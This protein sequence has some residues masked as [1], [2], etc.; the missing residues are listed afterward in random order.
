MELFTGG[1]SEQLFHHCYFAP[2]GGGEAV[3]VLPASEGRQAFHCTQCGT[4]VV[5]GKKG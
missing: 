3:I 4:V 1:Q 5:V 2:D